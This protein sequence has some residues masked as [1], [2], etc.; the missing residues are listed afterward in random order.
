MQEGIARTIG[1]LD[2]AEPFVRVVPFDGG[3][4]RRAG[5]AVELG[6]ARRCISE[7]A[8]RRLM[9]VIVDTTATGWTKISV[10]TAH[11]TSWGRSNVAQSEMHE[12]RSS[13]N[14]AQIRRAAKG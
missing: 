14:S 11:V 6:T 7:I 9:V 5:G 1:Y 8:G 2:E 10:S 12:G 13:T 4:D 3:S